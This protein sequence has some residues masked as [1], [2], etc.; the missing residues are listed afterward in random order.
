MFVPKIVVEWFGLNAELVRNLQ[1]ELA[2]ARAERD[3]LK[4]QLSVA[5]NN[6][7]WARQKLNMLEV[8][9]NGLMERAYNIKLPIP[10]IVRVPSFDPNAKS[11]NFEDMG[12]KLAKTLGYPSHA[13]PYDNSEDN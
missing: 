4:V 10:E 13:G 3:A 1:S 11:F 8:E 12:E 6:F 7:E 2:V 5:Q 9:R